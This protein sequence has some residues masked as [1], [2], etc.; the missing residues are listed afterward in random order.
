VLQI[1]ARDR[2]GEVVYF[3]DLWIPPTRRRLFIAE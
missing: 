2:A 3:Q 1:A